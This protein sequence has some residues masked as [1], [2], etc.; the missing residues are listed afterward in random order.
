MDGETQSGKIAFPSTTLASDSSQNNASLETICTS[1]FP[2]HSYS[3]I[4]QLFRIGANTQG[5][6][7][8]PLQNL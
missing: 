1:P 2:E 5:E 7:L 6:K 4:V 3:V 8:Y